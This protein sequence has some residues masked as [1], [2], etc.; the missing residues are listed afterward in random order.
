MDYASMLAKGHY[1]DR[2]VDLYFYN[3]SKRLIGVLKTPERGMKPSITVK[4]TFIEGS[5]AISSYI[6]IQN[7]SYT[8][9]VNSVAYIDCHMYYSGLANSL[10]ASAASDYAKKGH[11]VFFSVLYADQEKEPP[12][13]AVRF[14]CTVAAQDRNRFDMAVQVDTTDGKL[15][16][17]F[18]EDGVI[19]PEGLGGKT[20]AVEVTVLDF[21]KSLAKAYNSALHKDEDKIPLEERKEVRWLNDKMEIAAIDCSAENGR[22]RLKVNP[23]TYKFGEILRKLNSVQTSGKKF[24]N[25]KFAV[26]GNIL[27]V[28]TVVPDNWE[29]IAAA[30]GCVSEDDFDRFYLEN[31]GLD[32]KQ[33]TYITSTAT[34]EKKNPS[35]SL[36]NPVM[37]NFVTAA[38]RTEVVVHVSTLYD[39]RIRSGAYVAIKANA[40]MGRH[41]G[42]GKRSGSRM[43]AMTDK[44]VLIRV[45]G[46]VEYEF[47]TTEGSSMSF[48]GPV[49]NDDWKGLAVH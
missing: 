14:Q 27:E 48:V 35:G 34:W 22:R 5:Y 49:V 24:V 29:R 9:D 3:E 19:V 18:D 41:K 26:N 28:S 1:F 43:V 7:M 16:I 44:T 20:E 42:G 31:Y 38:Y 45:T 23:K 2:C 30:N 15:D 4:G 6:S 8:V 25:L 33:R 10:T 11:A 40:I 39:D 17:E 21:M 37:L 13:R 36:K 32:D 47:S 46:A 12:N